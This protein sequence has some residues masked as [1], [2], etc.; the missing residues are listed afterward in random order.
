MP[1]EGSALDALRCNLV[2]FRSATDQ[3]QVSLELCHPANSRD[4]RGIEDD[5]RL[6]RQFLLESVSLDLLVFG[7]VENVRERC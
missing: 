6:R 2:V 5:L 4:V 1:A 7:K 3:R